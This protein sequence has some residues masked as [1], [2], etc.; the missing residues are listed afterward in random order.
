MFHMSCLIHWVLL[1]EV[2]SHAKQSKEPKPKPVSTRK[3]KGK[4]GGKGKKQE[5]PTR[6]V[7]CPEC[8][9]SGVRIDG[10]VEIPTIPLSEVRVIL[11]HTCL[12]LTILT[13][14]SY[15]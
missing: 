7:F 14:A 3:V 11:R 15:Y 9:G 12:S 1:C 5:K 2:E 6:S 13:N 8:Q 10:N 4:N